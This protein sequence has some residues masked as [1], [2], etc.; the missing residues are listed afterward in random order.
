MTHSVSLDLML[1]ARELLTT[2]RTMPMK[3][4]VLNICLTCLV[5]LTLASFEQGHEKD[6]LGFRGKSLSVFGHS[7]TSWT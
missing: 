5:K 6:V 7:G 4:G 1:K 2:M 3:H